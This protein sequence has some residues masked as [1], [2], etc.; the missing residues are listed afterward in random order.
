[1]DE[2][3]SVGKRLRAERTRLGYNVRQFAKEGGI[4]VGTQSRYENDESPPKSE[5]LNRISALGAEIFWIMRGDEEDDE[6]RDKRAA[7]YPPDVREL[8]DDYKLC[9]DEVKAALRVMA[10]QAADTKRQAVAAFKKK[11]GGSVV[12]IDAA[13]KPPPVDEA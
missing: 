12:K 5:Y 3:D 11:H 13:T 9:P 10:K 1:M 6:V 7:M 2:P 8:I 4:G